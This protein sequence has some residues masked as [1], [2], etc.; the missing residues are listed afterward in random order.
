MDRDKELA[1]VPYTI[2]QIEELAKCETPTI[3]LSIFEP[4][5][6]ESTSKEQGDNSPWDRYKLYPI[7]AEI[8]QLT[9]QLAEVVHIV[10]APHRIVNLPDGTPI[11]ASQRVDID[12]QGKALPM[13]DLCQIS[14][15]KF[16]ERYEGSYEQ[17]MELIEECSSVNKIDVITLW[18]HIAFAWICGNSD[19]NLKEIALYE[20]YNGICSLVP[21]RFTTS[22]ALI[23]PEKLGHL[24]LTLNNKKGVIQRS[25]LEAAMKKSGLKNR[26]INIMFKKFVAAREAWFNLIDQSS[27]GSELKDSYKKLLD[28]QLK[29]LE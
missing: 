27:L 18:E 7:G 25:D 20:P 5:T 1:E 4:T 19:F 11:F 12:S 15:L 26:P 13:E 28:Q 6:I 14:E 3:P 16:E 2:E 9:M 29:A 24:A 22:T 23:N 17:V 8:A 10:T 21:L